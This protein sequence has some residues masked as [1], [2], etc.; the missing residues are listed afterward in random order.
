[1]GTLV[2]ENANVGD[3]GNNMADLVANLAGAILAMPLMRF[4]PDRAPF[5]D[6]T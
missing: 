2:V 1:V 4:G 6:P 3:Y 5:K